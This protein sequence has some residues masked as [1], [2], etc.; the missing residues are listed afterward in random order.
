VIYDGK[1]AQASEQRPLHSTA[2]CRGSLSRLAE[3]DNFSPARLSFNSTSSPT[4]NRNKNQL[5]NTNIYEK[6][7]SENDLTHKQL[8]F[9]ISKQVVFCVFQKKKNV[10]GT[11]QQSEFICSKT[12]KRRS[13]SSS[14]VR[15]S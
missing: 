9:L 13:S 10:F 1:A 7:T 14:N 11:L 3:V 5:K 2:F 4:I 15:L 12:H 6:K 8:F